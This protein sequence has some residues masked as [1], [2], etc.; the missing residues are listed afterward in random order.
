MSLY[1]KFSL[2]HSSSFNCGD[3]L[4]DANQF[5]DE[6]V[7]SDDDV[8]PAVVAVEVPE[9]KSD[10]VCELCG[11]HFGKKIN[12]IR[13]R[14]S[15]PELKGQ[16]LNKYSCTQ[17]WRQF[18]LRS[19]LDSHLK[20]HEEEYFQSEEVKLE[21]GV[22][23]PIREEGSGLFSN[24][25]S[26]TEL[27][28]NGSAELQ[29]HFS[30]N[31]TH[32]DYDAFACRVCSKVLATKSQW[33]NHET[34]C[35]REASPESGME[36][37]EN[38][39]EECFDCN[40]CEESFRSRQGFHRHLKAAHGKKY[41]C[42]QCGKTF[43]LKSSLEKHLRKHRPKVRPFKSRIVAPKVEFPFR[44]ESGRFFCLFGGCES[45]RQSFQYYNGLKEHFLLKHAGEDLK[46]FS[47]NYCGQKFG[48]NGLRNKH[49][50]KIHE[51]RFECDQG[52][53]L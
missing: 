36:A 19:R 15:H 39:D 44:E 37:A 30:E 26:S 9:T 50:Y 38:F 8:K 53:M 40:Q 41:P 12:L 13:H 4:D 43:R 3:D 22:E 24:K 45:S 31:H 16:N 10:H 51:H 6:S 25:C 20:L 32:D 33:D 46:L 47:C 28:L 42:D 52:P 7:K 35:A 49:E 23:L 14:K 11:R 17:C 5:D 27:L 29:P 18:G 1:L 2:Y 48:T 34:V 21:E